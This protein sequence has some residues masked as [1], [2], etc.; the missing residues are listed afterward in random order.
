MRRLA[1][2]LIALAAAH[3]PALTPAP[4]LAQPAGL[5]SRATSESYDQA[6]PRL[7]QAIA[8]E[9]MG[10]VTEAGPTETA[11]ARGETIPG[12]RVLGVF[13]NDFAVRAIRACPGAMIAPPIRF[14]LQATQ[15][16][17]RLDWIR[18]SAVFAPWAAACG[19]EIEALGA[20]LDPIFE[21]IAARAV[22]P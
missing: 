13:R 18:P 20:E 10:L 17:A 22:A 21:A 3:S 14:H 1:C 4:A 16:G 11:A 2:A 19:P 6:L 12:D 7:R 15:T 8:A 9:K 5:E